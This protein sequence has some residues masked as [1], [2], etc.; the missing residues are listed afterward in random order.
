MWKKVLLDILS[1]LKDNI[2]K[3]ILPK[4]RAGAEINEELKKLYKRF[5]DC[6]DSSKTFSLSSM[7][8]DAISR[9]TLPNASD[10]NI[11]YVYRFLEYRKNEVILLNIWLRFSVKRI[12]STYLRYAKENI[13]EFLGILIRTNLLFKDFFNYLENNKK[14][15]VI[16]HVIENLKSNGFP[17]FKNEYE[18]IMKKLFNLVESNSKTLKEL[19]EIKRENYTGYSSLPMW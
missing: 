3:Y 1:I 2:F 16:K 7:M 9:L 4:Y 18:D 19:N 11:K 17:I 6:L 14:N 13:E 15:E 10:D 8:N 12:D 5:S